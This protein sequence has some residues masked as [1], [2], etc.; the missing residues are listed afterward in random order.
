MIAVWLYFLR[1]AAWE[2][3]FR[4]GWGGARRAD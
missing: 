3:Y 4:T 2:L 1:E